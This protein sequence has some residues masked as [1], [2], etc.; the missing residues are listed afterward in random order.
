[1]KNLFLFSAILISFISSAQI[2]VT[3]VA[4]NA[5][6]TLVNKNLATANVTLSKLMAIQSAAKGEAVQT[7]SN[8]LKTL[9]ESE[10]FM[11]ALEKVSDAVSGLDILLQ[12]KDNKNELSALMAGFQKA[13][14][15]SNMESNN[16]AL[17]ISN[18]AKIFNDI[19]PMIQILNKI[20]TSGV[21]KANDVDRLK[22]IMEIDRQIKEQLKKMQSMAFDAMMFSGIQIEERN[23]KG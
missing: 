13:L 20:L 10:K 9:K 22:I 18:S 21:L 7:A 15:N 14:S 16:K 6:L 19:K 12:I 1:M 4:A 17:Y 8:T 23:F 5:N 2:P 3:D 11:Q